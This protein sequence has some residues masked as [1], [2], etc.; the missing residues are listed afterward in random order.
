[1][2]AFVIGT[3]SSYAVAWRIERKLISHIQMHPPL[4]F[5]SRNGFQFKLS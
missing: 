5:W 4:W 1:M 2:P 3:F